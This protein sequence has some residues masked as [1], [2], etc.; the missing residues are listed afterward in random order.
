M[1]SVIIGG[2][3]T[4]QGVAGS[5]DETDPNN[6]PKVRIATPN[7]TPIDGI[8]VTFALSAPDR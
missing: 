8:V 4:V 2:G 7:G 1:A 3:T 5:P 6:L